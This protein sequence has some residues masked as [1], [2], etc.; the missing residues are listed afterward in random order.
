[1]NVKLL[2][3]LL[4]S[5]PLSGRSQSA[6]DS[7]NHKRAWYVPEGVV[8]QHA[9][10]M[11]FLAVG[12]SYDLFSKKVTADILYGFVPKY[13]AKEVLHLATLKLTYLPYKINIGEDYSVTPLRVGL[14]ASVY[15]NDQLSLN[16]AE[17]YPRGYYWWSEAVRVLGF[18]GA[19]VNRDF[20]NDMFLKRLSLYGEVGTYDLIVTSWIR[21]KSIKFG[22]IL[23]LS[24][25]VRASF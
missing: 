15:F 18:A 20:G 2:L 10:N 19:S 16:W 1:M 4:L 7:L 24:V 22:D 11:G 13:Q 23:S 14:G 25:G 3:L 12:P 9:G 5:L 21:D 6:E 8:V 17:D